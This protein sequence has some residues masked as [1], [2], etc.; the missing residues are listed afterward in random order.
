MT[1]KYIFLQKKNP[2]AQIKITKGFQIIKGLNYILTSFYIVCTTF[3]IIH[4]E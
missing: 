4:K 2:V 1:Q 3:N